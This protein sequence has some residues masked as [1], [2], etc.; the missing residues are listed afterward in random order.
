MASSI[1][2]L[3]CEQCGGIAYNELNCRTLEEWQRCHRCGCGFDYEAKRNKK[4]KV[5][6]NRKKRPKYRFKK[7]KGYGVV[8]FCFKDGNGV[9]YHLNKALSKKNRK[10]FFLDLETNAEIDKQKSYS[11]IW[12]KKRKQIVSLYG[13]IPPSFEDWQN[14]INEE[15]IIGEGEKL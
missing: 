8:Y 2:Y 13:D 7:L 5:I 4:G 10:S 6:L 9:Y 12:D 15:S 14:T 1:D 3:K 11:T